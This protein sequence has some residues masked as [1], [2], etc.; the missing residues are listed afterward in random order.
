[1]THL[2][3][4]NYD[5]ALSSISSIL[6]I[7]ESQLIKHLKLISDRDDIIHSRHQ[8]FDELLRLNCQSTELTAL[9][10]HGTRVIETSSFFDAG[11]MPKSYSYKALEPL[12]ND[13]AWDIKYANNG[14]SMFALPRFGKSQLGLDDEGPFAT[15]FKQKASNADYHFTQCPEAVED[16]AETLVGSNFPRLTEKFIAIS[17]PAIV[18]FIGLANL[19]SLENA[20]LYLHQIIHGESESEAAQLIDD[21]YQGEGKVIPGKRI[22]AIHFLDTNET[23]KN[24]EYAATVL[25]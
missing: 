11:L 9:W 21:Y 18:E 16:I 19:E 25:P 13:L 20:L 1:M 10:F 2:D 6:S 12:L 5:S 8:C 15:L 23:I 17:R 3:C 4:S 24:P 14:Q 22:K 7:S